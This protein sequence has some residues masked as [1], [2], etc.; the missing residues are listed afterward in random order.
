MQG[1]RPGTRGMLGLMALGG[2]AVAH[3]AAGEKLRVGISPCAPCV[4]CTAKEP[5]GVAID[6]WQVIART[7]ADAPGWSV[8]YQPMDSVDVLARLVL[9][10]RLVDP[11]QI[12]ACA[13]LTL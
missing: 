11:Q 4:M 1:A 13:A 8:Q 10:P 3:A 2:C 9:R 7:W 6:A 12:T 5:E